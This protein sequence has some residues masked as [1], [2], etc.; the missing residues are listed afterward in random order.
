MTILSWGQEDSRRW[1]AG[2][3]H[4]VFYPPADPAVVWNGLITVEENSVGGEV[5]TSYLDGIRY[6]VSVGS[7]D[8]QAKLTAFSIP[9]EMRDYVG[10]R[11]P[12]KGFVLAKQPKK[13][14]N[15][16][17]QTSGE[18]DNYKIHLIFNALATPDSSAS[19]SLG[20]SVAPANPTWV[21]DA[22]PV[23][24]PGFRPSAHLVVDSR[25]A[26]GS[27]MLELEQALYGSES[28][29]PYFPILEE[30]LDIFGVLV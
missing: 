28:T 2:V 6:L 30:L 12:V 8:Y 7:T 5:D 25:H 27:V 11:Q 19:Q 9:S 23:D 3:S 29:D 14:F 18:D 13:R 4:G 20:D 17:Y 24:I 22:T 16:S 21:I 26:S 10:S 15:F 1:E